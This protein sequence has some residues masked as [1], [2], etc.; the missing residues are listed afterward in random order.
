LNCREYDA[1]IHVRKLE[2]LHEL[3]VEI[4]RSELLLS[5]AAKRGDPN[6]PEIDRNA[7]DE[8]IRSF[9]N[10]ARILVKNANDGWHT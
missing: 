4:A 3:E 7:F 10:N 1:E 9:V 8:L 5:T 2:I 6:V